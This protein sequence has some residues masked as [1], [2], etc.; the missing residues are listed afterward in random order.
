VAL[1]GVDGNLRE[2][3]ADFYGV[4]PG[5]AGYG[6]G[7]LLVQQ[8]SVQFRVFIDGQ[9]AFESPPLK[10]GQ[11]PWRFDVPI[12]PGS[13]QINLTVTDAGS[14]SILDLA[15]WVDAG[16]VLRKN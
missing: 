15:D 3:R 2:R 16:F 6:Y 14:R 4:L 1:A 8:P 10:L 13:R 11:E 5:D 7:C 12:P 9:P